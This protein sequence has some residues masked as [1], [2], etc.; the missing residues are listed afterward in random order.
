MSS[1]EGKVIRLCDIDSIVIPDDMK[2]V[3][4][5]EGQIEKDIQ[6]L[7]IRYAKESQAENVQSGD[8]VYCKADEESY[9]DGRTVI[10]YTGMDIP[11]AGKA[12]GDVANKHVGDTFETEI[13]GKA[14]K[15]MVDKIVRRVPVPVTDDL[16]ASMGIDGVITV[17]GYREY[18]TEKTRRD[19]EMEN[20]KMIIAHYIDAMVDGSTYEYDEKVMDEY[21][22]SG[23]EQFE[24]EY[25]DEEYDASPEEIR[26]GI[27]FQTKQMWMAKEFCRQKGLEVDAVSVAEETDKMIE[28]MELMGEDVPDREEML[29]MN[30][31]DEYFNKFIEYVQKKI[32]GK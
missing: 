4:V 17:D 3:T 28:M 27:I 13:S 19:L 24:Q 26:D 22:K 20:D 23:M 14:V 29:E 31:Q 32:E 18:A 15:L 7:S 1:I 2:G 25:Q 12:V 5:D 30:I 10:I 11:G 6:A 8:I 21:V 9:P 16:I